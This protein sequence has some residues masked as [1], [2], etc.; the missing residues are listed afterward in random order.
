M[1]TSEKMSA[2]LT[3]IIKKLKK[4]ENKEL[5]ELKSYMFALW[6]WKAEWKEIKRLK[7]E[8]ERTW[9]E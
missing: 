6:S 1:K 9:A 2:C 3:E 8:N 4:A 5:A 7:R